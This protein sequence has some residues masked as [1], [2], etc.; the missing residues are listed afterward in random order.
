[1]ATELPRH[2]L[3]A[4]LQARD[5][6][7]LTPAELV[8]HFRQEPGITSFLPDGTF[9]TDP[10]NG[11]CVLFNATRARRPQDNI[12]AG[13]RQPLEERACIICRGQTTGVVDMAELSQGFTF[14]NKNLFPVLFP[15]AHNQTAG[16]QSEMAAVSG[17]HFLQWT[18][19]LHDNDWHN[20]PASDRIIVMER[21][22][23]LERKLILDSDGLLA[24]PEAPA[25]E[26][27]D[28]G[29]VLITKNYGR[30]VGGSLIH[31]HQQIALS[32]V[33]PRRFD[34]NRRF[35]Q[36]QGE[37]FSSYIQRVN[38]RELTVKD[39]GPVVL[40]VPYFMR[41]PYDMMLLLKNV[42]RRY[43]HQLDSTEI[44]AVADGWRDAIRAMR[45]IM[46]AIGRETAYNVLT[47]SGPGAGLYFEFLPFTQEFGGFEQLGL[48]ICQ[49][50]P[51][52]AAG[53]IREILDESPAGA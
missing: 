17:L 3:D 33:A 43:L 14:V 6:G 16:V 7:E 44:G 46:P 39:Y 37:T 5:I 27:Q 23:A 42:G 9:A 50:D 48:L 35:E 18:S 1:M 34:D 11:D 51:I 28:A 15:F 40:L 47:N 41:R 30:L 49:A 10:R 8:E 53:R 19:S 29:S 21:L 45:A 52:E 13:A 22:A 31:G 12:P 20:M 25:A 2:L 24:G 32:S 26:G 38:P 36:V 4:L